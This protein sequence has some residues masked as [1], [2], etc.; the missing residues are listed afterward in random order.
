MLTVLI[1]TPWVNVQCF[2]LGTTCHTEIAYGHWVVPYKVRFFFIW[3]G[4]PRLSSLQYFAFSLTP[5]GFD[6]LCLAPFS[7]L[8]Q[9]YHGDQ[10]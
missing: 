2:F 6:L 7:R 9:L 8:F 5:Y 3:I 1:T 10:F 4:N